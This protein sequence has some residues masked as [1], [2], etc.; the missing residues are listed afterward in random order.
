MVSETIFKSCMSQFATGVNVVTT[1]SNQKPIGVTINSFASLSLNPKLILFNLKKKSFCYDDFD[2]TQKFAC[3]ILSEGQKEVS[4]F[5][6]KPA[7]IKKLN[8]IE[9]GDGK[10]LPCIKNSIAYIECSVHQK[11]DSG[12]HTIFVGKVDFIDLINTNYPP[13]INFRRN[14]RNLHNA[15]L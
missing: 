10:S 9:T 6:T 12:D 15:N 14:Y 13:L 2:N 7:D 1:I 11:F 8:M 3:N 4:D 5:F